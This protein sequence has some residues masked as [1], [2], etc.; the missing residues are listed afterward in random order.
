MESRRRAADGVITRYVYIELARGAKFDSVR[1]AVE[2]DPMF[3]GEQT[4]VSEV[5][6]LVALEAEG[7]GVVLERRGT[8]AQGAHQSLL[9]GRFEAPVF[10]ARVMLDAARHLPS[11]KSGAHDY[12][13]WA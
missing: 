8:A 2:S 11:L 7:H 6:S 3:A 4:L 12:S 13:F 10:A 9:E 1:A 5:P